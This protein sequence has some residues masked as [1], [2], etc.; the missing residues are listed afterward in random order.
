[1]PSYLLTPLEPT[2]LPP[3]IFGPFL[4]KYPLP[5]ARSGLGTLDF[6]YG[7]I[8]GGPGGPNTY[9][10]IPVGY[11]VDVRDAAK[12]HILALDTAPLKDGRDKR[13]NICK[14]FTWPEAAQVLREKRPELVGRLPG[15]EAVAI[16]QTNAP[17]DVQFAAD[18]LGLTKYISLEETIVDSIDYALR[19]EKATGVKA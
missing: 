2:V 3:L 4:S 9:P 6:V 11:M 1:M 16:P 10:P 5:A 13:I 14:T 8:T 7:L 18:V 15:A 17:V 19:W 12:A